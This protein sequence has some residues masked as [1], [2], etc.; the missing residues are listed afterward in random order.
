MHSSSYNL[1]PVNLDFVRRMKLAVWGD[2]FWPGD[3][4]FHYRSSSLIFLGQDFDCM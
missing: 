3:Q 2:R 4:N 1:L